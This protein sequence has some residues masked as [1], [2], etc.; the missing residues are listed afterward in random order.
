VLLSQY[1]TITGQRVRVIG[2]LSAG[3]RFF[4]AFHITVD[5]A[6]KHLLAYNDTHRV[7]AVDLTTGHLASITVGQIPYLDGAYNTAAW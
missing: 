7:K 6:G 4:T 5:A 3:G 2:Q 1:S